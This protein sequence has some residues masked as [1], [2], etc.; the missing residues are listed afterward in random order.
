[1]FAGVL[2]VHD[3]L[4]ASSRL[5]SLAHPGRRI[6]VVEAAVLILIGVGAALSGLLPDFHLRIPGHAILR[7]V[8]PMALGLALVP[9]RLGGSMMGASALATAFS[10][11]ASGFGGFGAGALTSLGLT[12]PLLDVALLWAGRGWHLYIAIVLA[13]LVSNLLALLVRGGLKSFSLDGP[14]G[15]LV[16]EWWMQALFTYPACGILA[17]LISAFFWFQLRRSQRIAPTGEMESSA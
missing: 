13:G 2:P 14:S 17:G 16:E 1:M 5:P 3:G 6:A 12:G 9:R 7:S 15:R 8:I 11:K 4:F 10:L